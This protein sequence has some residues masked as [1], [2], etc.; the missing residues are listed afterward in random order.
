MLVPFT[1]ASSLRIE[2][3][4]FGVG[5]SDSHTGLL[6]TPDALGFRFGIGGARCD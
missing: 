3:G 6:A 2:L 4:M 1:G 5:G